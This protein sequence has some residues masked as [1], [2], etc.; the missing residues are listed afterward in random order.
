MLDTF[1]QNLTGTA[2]IAVG[3]LYVGTGVCYMLADRF[4]C[5]RYYGQPKGA[6]NSGSVFLEYPSKAVE[7]FQKRGYVIVGI[8]HSG[9]GLAVKTYAE[10]KRVIK[11]E[12]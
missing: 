5:V 12:T 7:D 3:I 9:F 6:E 2:Y 1:V 11:V 4:K 8:H 10:L